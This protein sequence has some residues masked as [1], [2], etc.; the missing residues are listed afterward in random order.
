MNDRAFV[1]IVVSDGTTILSYPA[2]V[3]E[4][5]PGK[6]SCCIVGS[7]PL[8]IMADA[9]GDDLFSVFDDDEQTTTSKNVPASLTTEIG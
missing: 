7:V 2:A 4:V 5:L 6:A 8:T 9:F 1:A 3:P